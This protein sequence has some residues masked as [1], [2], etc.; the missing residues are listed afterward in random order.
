MK[1][2][3]LQEDHIAIK[4]L[5]NVTL[6]F[7]ADVVEKLTKAPRGSSKLEGFTNQQETDEYTKLR[8]QLGVPIGTA[9]KTKMLLAKL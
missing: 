7:N 1:V 4:V 6:N 2:S 9:I 8:E 5:P 3:E